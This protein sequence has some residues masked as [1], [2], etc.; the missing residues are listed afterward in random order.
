MREAYSQPNSREYIQWL[1]FGPSRHRKVKRLRS[2]ERLFVKEIASI[3][4]GMV[5][6]QCATQTVQICHDRE[7][8]RP[9]VVRGA[10]HHSSINKWFGIIEPFEDGTVLGLVQV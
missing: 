10:V 6:K 5:G 4:V 3:A 7:R 2:E 9:V 1:E 8:Q